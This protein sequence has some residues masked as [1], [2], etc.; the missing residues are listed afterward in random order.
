MLLVFQ[1]IWS[2]DPLKEHTERN[3]ESLNFIIIWWSRQVMIIHLPFHIYLP[4]QFQVANV[5]KQF[6]SET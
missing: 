1:I 5:I 6:K 4:R 3:Y 2:S